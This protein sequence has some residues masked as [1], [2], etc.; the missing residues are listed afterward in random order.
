MT[1]DPDTYIAEKG[2]FDPDAYLKEKEQKPAEASLG[3]R[4]VSG[5]KDWYAG[6]K[7]RAEDV[8]DAP[9]LPE[10]ALRLAGGAAGSLVD[11]PIKAGKAVLESAPGGQWLENNVKTAGEQ[12]GSI[13]LGK[14]HT[15]SDIPLGAKQM[16]SE[17]S[18]RTQ[19]NIGAIGNIT[20]VV[21]AGK[22]LG[23]GLEFV[24]KNLP[25]ITPE[26]KAMRE[27]AVLDKAI[28]VGID[29][30]I[31]PTFVGKK[32]LGRMEKFRGNVNDAVRTIAD[33]Q[34]N[35]KIL[36]DAGEAVHHPR[37]SAEM[38]QAIDQT[39]KIIYK[40]YHDMAIAA[41][42]A[43][44]EF[45][46]SPVISKL[47]KFAS[48]PGEVL[49]PKDPR[50]GLPEEIRNYADKIKTDIQEL[51]G[52]PPEIIEERIKHYNKSL[53][54]FY[55][56][57]VTREKAE[58]D[59]SVANALREELDD[60]IMGSVGEGYQGLKNQY[61]ALKASE[62]DVNHRALMQ[63]RRANKSVLDFTDV[64]T[65]GELIG[66]VLTLNPALI[67]RGAAGR[68]IKEIYKNLNN[69][70]RYI[71]KM[72]NEAYKGKGKL[73]G[74]HTD[75]EKAAVNEEMRTITPEVRMLRTTPPNFQRAIGGEAQKQLSAPLLGR[76]AL[77][78]RSP[79][80]LEPPGKY[81]DKEP[82]FTMPGERE[83]ERIL[84]LSEKQAKNENVLSEWRKAMAKKESSRLLPSP[85][86]LG[87]YNPNFTLPGRRESAKQLR[88]YYDKKL[89]GKNR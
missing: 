77:S 30:G 13:P 56:G 49:D 46:A 51:H 55:D 87:D 42:D 74:F 17:L 65:G 45:N 68:G 2:S 37:T 11:I 5:A 1:F 41:G 14:G 33:N 75:A 67:A 57:R 48:K 4:I 63:A 61:G 6:A 8:K 3:S 89:R 79:K 76:K 15:L 80:Q 54:G 88:I 20:G 86:K 53:Q 10:K 36:D 85:G 24:G 44:A 78:D 64:F 39:K 59:A 16:F 52:A 71:E 82:G 47:D 81:S 40:Q 25:K 70:D 19:K 9:T 23:T 27:G 26:A 12:I 34:S 18:P 29:K 72:F 43:G 66:G 58:I 38:A 73:S 62:R 7:Q 60:E 31:K 32:D 21:P 35:I 50:L 83:S 69:P 28:D 22:L 84:R